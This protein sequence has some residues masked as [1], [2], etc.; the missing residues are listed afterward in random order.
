MAID[1]DKIGK[2]LSFSMNV[3][4]GFTNWVND[5][6]IMA[7]EL[8]EIGLSVSINPISFGAWYRR[9]AAGQ[10]RYGGRLVDSLA[11]HHSSYSTGC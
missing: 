9:V 3:V 5:C 2:K 1:V 10:L 11:H 7:G 6:Q 4:N 8:K